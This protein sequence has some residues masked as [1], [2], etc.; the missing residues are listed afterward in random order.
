MD[1]MMRS[2]PAAQLEMVDKGIGLDKSGEIQLL[3][4]PKPPRKPRKRRDKKKKDK[5]KDDDGL[6]K[7][8]ATD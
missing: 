1:F 4:I 7:L 5:D 8:P 3:P 2:I 6:P